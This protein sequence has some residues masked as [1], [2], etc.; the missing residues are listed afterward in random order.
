MVPRQG[1]TVKEEVECKAPMP[2]FEVCNVSGRTQ[3]SGRSLIGGS[4]SSED[5]ASVVRYRASVDG[6]CS[7]PIQTCNGYRT[8][9]SMKS[10]GPMSSSICLG[11]HFIVVWVSLACKRRG[12]DWHK[13]H[14]VCISG[15]NLTKPA[16]TK[17]RSRFVH[18]S[19]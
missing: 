9:G 15:Q 4:Q 8:M 18:V 7:W 14:F 13:C 12:C 2:M 11:I 19:T 10:G 5:W 3:Q 6:A 17:D 16:C 1:R